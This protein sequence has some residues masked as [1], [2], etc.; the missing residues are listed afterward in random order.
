MLKHA[1]ATRADITVRESNGAL[2]VRVSDDGRGGGAAAAPGLG[3]A[4]MRSRATVVG[5]DL[6]AGPHPAGGYE[7][8]A[9]LPARAEVA[10]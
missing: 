4:G 9:T 3:I 10:P 7:V 1:G 6:D 8:C 2:E 5:G